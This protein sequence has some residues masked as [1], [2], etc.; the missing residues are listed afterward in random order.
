[1]KK[2]K[3]IAFICLAIIIIALG[4]FTYKT[5]SSSNKSKSAQEKSLSEV[6]FLEIKLV[7][8]FNQMNTI[9]IR[10]YNVSVK[11]IAKL[12]S[13]LLKKLQNYH[14]IKI[15]LSHLKKQKGKKLVRKVKQRK[16]QRKRIRQEKKQVIVIQRIARVKNLL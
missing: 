14:Q 12:P 8:L 7:N 9:E 15:T 2:H 16:K 3:T 4:I 13:Y 11:E 10:N 6:E 5:I 1:M